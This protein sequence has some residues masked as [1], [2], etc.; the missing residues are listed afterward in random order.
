MKA[1]HLLAAVACCGCAST[2]ELGPAENL[3]ASAFAADFAEFPLR[4]VAVLPPRGLEGDDARDL[5]KQFAAEIAARAP[6][7]VV[8]LASADLVDLPGV[9]H[10]S[11]V[12]ERAEAIVAL[13]KR[14]D[15]DAFYAL[16][17]SGR[18]TF[19]P[20]H[21]TLEADLVGA[22]TGARLWT[23]QG[24]WN[25]ADRRVRASLESWFAA[26]RGDAESDEDWSL[27]LLAPRK[28]AAY[29][30]SQL[31]ERFFPPLVPLA[32]EPPP[33]ENVATDSW[34]R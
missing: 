26:Q 33:V 3:A 22:E 24:A 17:V 11:Q 9:T 19:A 5:Q 29:A 18:T 31:A 27:Y 7:E 1:L 12:L 34:Q 30:C 21:L 8:T 13:S 16:E 20:L 25:A 2:P 6:F 23:A 14:H 32:V 15:L 4:R 28:F 10:P